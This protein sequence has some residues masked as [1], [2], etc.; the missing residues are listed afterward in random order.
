ML[1]AKAQ[2][3]LSNAEKY[4]REHLS[5]GDHHAK[6]DYYSE[7]REV[8][9]QW[10]GAGADQ[11]KLRGKVELA[12][13]VKL[14]HNQNPNTDELLTQRM[15]S[16]RRIFYD[17]TLSP[18]K[19]VSIAALVAGDSRLE[20][21]HERATHSA[22]QELEKFAAARVRKDGASTYRQTGNIVSAIFR[23]DTSRALDPHLHCHC[24]VFNATFDK[25]EQ[26]WKALE[27]Y[28]MLQAA[29]Y[30]ENVY[31]HELAQELRRFGYEFQNN[32]RG[33]FEIEN[34][35]RELID[36]FSKRHQEIDEKTRALLDSEPDK[37]GQNLKEIRE[38]IAHNERAR[39]IKNIGR[40]RLVE[41]WHNQ[42]NDNDRSILTKLTRG[43]HVAPAN[44]QALLRNS[45][46]WAEEHLFDRK[47]VTNEF[48]LWRHAL[49][50]GR[51]E[52]FSLQQLQSA[53]SRKQYVRNPARPG[54][55][56]TQQTLAREQQI[57][58]MAQ[59]G[60]SQFKSFNDCYQIKN[61]A[62]DSEQRE[63]V[64]RLLSSKDFVTLFRGGAGTGKSFTLEEV[65][66]GLLQ[67]G[68]AVHIIAPQRQQVLDLEA[69]LHCRGA[70]ISEFLT[71]EPIQRGSVVIVDEAGQIGA[72]QMSQLFDLVQNQD[73]RLILSGDT[74]QHGAVEASDALR[75][76]EKFGGLDAVELKTIRR[77][78]PE[79]AKTRA[80]RRSIEEYKQAVVEARNG[81]LGASFDRLN[82]NG[83]IIQCGYTE[84]QR[85]LADKF[86]ELTASGNS[87]V[88]VSQTWSEIHKV[89]E[90]I[91]L[92]LKSRGLVGADEVTVTIL[93]KVDL[94][95]AQKCD[96]RFYTDETV[97]I[98][99]QDLAGFKRGTQATLVQVTG[100]ELLVRANGRIRRIP[101]RELARVSVCQPK[102]M[103]VSAGDRLQ[104][105]ANIKTKSG[106]QFANGELVTIEK[107][108][109]DGQIKLRDGRT[110]PG[111]YRQFTRGYAITSYAAQ[112]KTGDYVIF[113]DSAIQSATNQKQ[114]YV[115][116]SRGR[117][118]VHIFT[119]DKQELRENI[120]RMG[121]RELA[122]E[123]VLQN[124][125]TTRRTPHRVRLAC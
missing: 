65:R 77:Q 2:Y 7:G 31:Y 4:F 82:K 81:Q 111:D 99:N 112:G 17:F 95:D 32:N 50:R 73:S 11:L 16:T 58:S 93:E 22:L 34:I 42:T 52:K 38:R 122:T 51:G 114:W 24:V 110:M 49:E 117:K 121:N 43:R 14:C 18:P 76:I 74:K 96:A 118:G 46:T 8:M 35:P 27:T 104:L 94:T 19:S 45:I 41:L 54:K 36:R 56:T 66:T 20:K 57:I 103:A 83:A 48:E 85:F 1:S 123:L 69:Q 53:T 98:F 115:T 6:A 119:T 3:H 75:A 80:E 44:N 47:S 105:K 64:K 97:L 90:E 70:T 109:D 86:L 78:N 10:F 87:V 108:H 23:H 60:R 120:T 72:K 12:D 102:R 71:H 59:N 63:A 100:G 62:L 101:N 67:A 28:E 84:Q 21:A 13:F 15:K 79:L 37:R 29:K 113:S 106:T 30:V 125:T 91:R 124:I 116:I 26:R 55:I 25:T 40:Q 88:V 33:D 92:G 5:V 39:K 68:Y 9:G 61:T 89:N 107:V